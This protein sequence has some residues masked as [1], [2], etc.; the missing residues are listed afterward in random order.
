MIN[1]FYIKKTIK[2][3]FNKAIILN[4]NK[5]VNLFLPSYKKQINYI[6]CNNNK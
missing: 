5:Y 1:I 2:N 4:I 6:E 3:R